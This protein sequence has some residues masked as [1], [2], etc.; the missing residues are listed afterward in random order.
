MK[1]ILF[2]FLALVFTACSILRQGE[3]DKNKAKWQE[4]E[5]LHYRYH[6]DWI[7]FC[8]FGQDMPLVIEVQNGEVVSMKFFSGKTPNE[9]E[10][11]LFESIG[12]IDSIFT[13]LEQRI[14]ARPDYFAAEYDETYGFPV[15]VRVDGDRRITDDESTFLVSN[16]EVLP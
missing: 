7:C 15:E 5:I 12:T 11:V 2:L 13:M 6:F 3:L 16:F 9:T 14:S 1:R 10:R 8:S 4:A